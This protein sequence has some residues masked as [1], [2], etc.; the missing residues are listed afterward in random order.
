MD[1]LVDAG[2]W[3]LMMYVSGGVV[4]GS[5]SFSSKYALVEVDD[6]VVLLFEFRYSLPDVQAPLLILRH[7][8]RV[9]LFHHLDLLPRDLVVLVELGEQSGIK[10]VSR[11][12]PSK[13]QASFFDRFA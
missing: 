1:R 9:D 7:L 5:D 10:Y 8:L 11:K 6:S 4:T 13:Q 12:M 2:L 3:D